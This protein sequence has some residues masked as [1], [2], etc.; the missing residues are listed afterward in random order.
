[1]LG[2]TGRLA[3]PGGINLSRGIV[4]PLVVV[5]S[6]RVIS[7]VMAG[8]SSCRVALLVGSSSIPFVAKV[9]PVMSTEPGGRKT[10]GLCCPVATGCTVLLG[11]RREQEGNVVGIAVSD[12]GTRRCGGV[13]GG[14]DSVLVTS[15][16][17]VL[18]GCAGRKG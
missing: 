10:C 6:V 8:P 15:S 11:G 18:M 7:S 14:S 5:V 9:R 4:C 12:G 2:G 16:T 1:M 17:G 3:S 13:V